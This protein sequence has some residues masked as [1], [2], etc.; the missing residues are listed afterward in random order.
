MEKFKLITNSAEPKIIGTRNGV[1]QVEFEDEK[2]EKHP[3]FKELDRIFISPGKRNIAEFNKEVLNL[4]IE[5]IK[6]ELI[7]R[8]KITDFMGFC[9][10]FFG[11]NYLISENVNEAFKESQIDKSEINLLPIELRNDN[12]K[13]F[14]LFA[15][16]IPHEEIIFNESILYPSRQQIL[17]K[18]DYLEINSFEEYKENIDKSVF[19]NFERIVLPNKYK[20]K[21]IISIQGVSG[22]FFSSKLAKSCLN[23]NLTSFR[24]SNME[25]ELSFK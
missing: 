14:I 18:K 13:Y 4:K 17:E 11:C 25:I 21:S 20:T 1:Y 23:R 6:G 9:P 10:Y 5:T 2:L 22:L 15:P 19:V 8:A 12:S 7:K 16:M 3:N 24:F